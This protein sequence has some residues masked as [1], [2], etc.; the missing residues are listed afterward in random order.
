MKRKM[1]RKT[2][3]LIEFYLAE[4]RLPKTREE[5]GGVKVGQYLSG[6]RCG[7]IN[8]T[9]EDIRK[10]E[11][12]GIDIKIKYNEYKMHRIV[13]LLIEFYELNG[14][15]PKYNEEYKNV[16]LGSYFSRL[17]RGQII[18]SNEYKILLSEA[19]IEISEEE[20]IHRNVILLAEFY[21]KNNRLPYNSEIYKKVDLKQ[22]FYSILSGDSVINT[23]DM[24]LLE[25]AGI[26]L[27]KYKEQNEN[28]D[29]L[30]IL[31]LMNGGYEFNVIMQLFTKPNQ[32][33]ENAA[34][35]W[36]KKVLDY[37]DTRSFEEKNKI[38][39][40]IAEKSEFPTF[41]LA[42]EIAQSD[43]DKKGFLKV[44]K[45]TAERYEKAL[46]LVNRVPYLVGI[47]EK[48]E[49]KLKEVNSVKMTLPRGR[50]RIG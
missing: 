18:L 35:A 36:E 47:K 13:S 38:L 5:Y 11:E 48:R 26:I 25:N 45:I 10:F 32:K 49:A 14:R 9:A 19:G 43:L 16:K 40:L 39:D 6:I 2:K 46:L 22:F 30:D 4:N 24:K 31:G 8:L 37:A 44:R 29:I 33:L 20:E 34:K 1:H 28:E 7:N 42:K 21:I 15:L 23:D 17:R 50:I 27:G 41:M 12:A 3:F